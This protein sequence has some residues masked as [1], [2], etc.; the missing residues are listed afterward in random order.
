[1][2]RIHVEVVKRFV[3]NGTIDGH[4][5][6]GVTFRITGGDR[7][8]RITFVSVNWGRGYQPG[9]FKANVLNVLDKV[10][11]LQYVVL[12]IQELDEADEA[13][14]RKIFMA[15]MERGTTLVPKPPRPGRETIAVS[16]GVKVHR[17]RPVMTMDQ[18]T[19][20]G[21]PEGTGPRRFFVSCVLVI[22]GVHI[23]VGDQHPHRN[24]PGESKVVKAR[25]RGEQV[26]EEQVAILVHI[27]D[28]VVHGGD[29]NDLN[30]PKSHPKERVGIEHGLDTIRWILA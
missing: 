15:E 21:A 25:Q 3:L 22:E 4:E 8:F 23:G 5:P 26:T 14:E 29:M 24:M 9:E 19:K 16:P 28:L 1:M 18:G 20:I 27:C 12:L 11:E 7:P 30:Y 17:R 2:P 6:I 13:P 10:D